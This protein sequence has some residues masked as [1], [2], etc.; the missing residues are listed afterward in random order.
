[1]N[2]LKVC[3]ILVKNFQLLGKYYQKTLG[4][5]FLVAPCISGLITQLVRNEILL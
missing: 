3:E 2:I 5:H 4:G 1:M